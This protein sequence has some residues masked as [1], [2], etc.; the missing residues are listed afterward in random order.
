MQTKPKLLQASWIETPKTFHFDDACLPQLVLYTDPEDTTEMKNPK[1]WVRL[2]HQTAGYACNHSLLNAM[3]LPMKKIYQEF[4]QKIQEEYLD[5][6]VW[7]PPSFQD[8]K[9]YQEQLESVGLGANYSYHLLEEGFYPIDPEHI[10]KVSQKR[11]PKNLESLKKPVK[12]KSFPFPTH[13]QCAVLG[14]NCD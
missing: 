9:K 6:C 7:S 11:L 5:S 8:A 12:T 10:H 14:R 13:W 4:F 1:E 2:Y 3:I